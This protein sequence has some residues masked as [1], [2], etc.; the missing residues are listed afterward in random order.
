MRVDLKEHYDNAYFSKSIQLLS[1]Q[2]ASLC[3]EV[4]FFELPG[5]LEQSYVLGLFYNPF[6]DGSK[7]LSFDKVPLLE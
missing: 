6:Q 5:Y 2:F 7:I 4:W 1:E 3:F